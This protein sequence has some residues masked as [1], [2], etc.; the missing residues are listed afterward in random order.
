[1]ALWKMQS[2]YSVGWRSS[3]GAE[4]RTVLEHAQFAKASPCDSPTECVETLQ[5]SKILGGGGGRY[6][7][8][9]A[10]LR[11]RSCKNAPPTLCASGLGGGG[12][13]RGARRAVATG[14]AGT[15]DN[16]GVAGRPAA[17]KAHDMRRSMAGTQHGRALLGRAGDRLRDKQA[18]GPGGAERTLWLA[19][20]P[21]LPRLIAAS[22]AQSNDG[23]RGLC[24][25][26]LGMGGSGGWAARASWCSTSAA[27]WRSST[28]S[29]SFN[30]S[31][32]RSVQSANSMPAQ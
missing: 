17:C 4:T 18:P 2:A 10:P 6:T 1:M 29:R 27:A 25:Y 3:M 32:A 8:S 30:S 31:C 22:I 5:V 19:P 7:G 14:W 16:F 11:T 28:C 9:G 20:Q 13:G 21:M 26:A 15:S 12:R 24:L 23:C